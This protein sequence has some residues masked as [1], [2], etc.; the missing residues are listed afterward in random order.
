MYKEAKK[1]KYNFKCRNC[2]NEDEAPKIVI[3][4][5]DLN[6]KN[7]ELTDEILLLNIGTHNFIGNISATDLESL[8]DGKWVTDNIISLVFKNI[9]RDVDG[10][11]ITFV[12]P[13]VAQIF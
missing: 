5:K 13:G 12:D 8:D 3:K 2:E 4:N 1:H 7:V 11:K 9:Q 6:G 10:C